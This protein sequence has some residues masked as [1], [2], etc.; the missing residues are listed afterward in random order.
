MQ[1]E[2]G[3]GSGNKARVVEGNKLYTKAVTVSVEHETNHD[4]GLAFSVPFSQSPTAADDCIFYMIN[5]ADEDLIV[6]G[7]TCGVINCTADD[8]LYFKLG[9]AGTRNA[10]SD[11]T[12]VNNNAGSGNAAQ[13]TWEQGADLDGGA[14]TLTGGTEFDRLVMAGVTDK[15]SSHYNFE[16]DIILTKNNTMTAWV[17]GSATGT[18]YLTFHFNYHDAT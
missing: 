3:H 12:P 14:A 10:A 16:Q 18:W 8:T 13:G 9:D 1:I 5:S 4:E 6:E 11:L 15:T 17:G 2:D 7:V